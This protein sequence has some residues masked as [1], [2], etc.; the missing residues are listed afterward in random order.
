MKTSKLRRMRRG[1]TDVSIVFLHSLSGCRFLTG[2]CFT[3][4]DLCAL[5]AIVCLQMSFVTKIFLLSLL[6]APFSAGKIGAAGACLLPFDRDEPA[7]AVLL[8]HGT[9]FNSSSGAALAL[10]ENWGEFWGVFVDAFVRLSGG[11]DLFPSA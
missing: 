11:S 2:T 9:V 10:C 3:V 6:R 1:S 4:C 8:T 7:E 5:S